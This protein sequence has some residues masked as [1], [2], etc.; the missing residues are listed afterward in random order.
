MWSRGSGGGEIWLQNCCENCGF[1]FYQWE[2]VEVEFDGVV[3][4]GGFT[5]CASLEHVEV[6]W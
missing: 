2:G 5:C 4:V 6:W 3:T 1:W